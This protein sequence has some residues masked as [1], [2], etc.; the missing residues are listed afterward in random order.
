MRGQHISHRR[1]SQRRGKQ[2]KGKVKAEL[3]RSK[4]GLR[5]R[6]VRDMGYTE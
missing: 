6:N 1:Q 2:V 4:Y 5:T 3:Q